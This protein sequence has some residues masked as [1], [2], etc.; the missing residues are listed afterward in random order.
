MFILLLLFQ[1]VLA[2]FPSGFKQIWVYVGNRTQGMSDYKAHGMYHSQYEQ[3]E[4]VMKIMRYKTGGTFIDLAA[5]QA[6]H[7]SNTF[8][9]ER[10][11]DWSGVCIDANYYV[12]EDLARRKCTVVAAAVGREINEEIPFKYRSAGD[13]AAY[14]GLIKEG[15]KQEHRTANEGTVFTTTLNQIFEEF[16]LPHIIDYLSLDIE[17]AELYALSSFDWD[18]YSF[19]VITIEGR[20]ENIRLKLMHEGYWYVTRLGEDDLYVNSGL[21]G[22]G[23]ARD[24]IDDLIH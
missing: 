6:V 7:I 20:N 2:E 21:M 4:H 11:Y 22:Q 18:K 17:G 24:L 19:N 10:D 5:N 1:S 13:E 14:G 16:D 3:D 8:A 12:W 23:E 9:M 15:M